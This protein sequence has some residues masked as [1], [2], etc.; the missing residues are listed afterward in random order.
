MVLK[1]VLLVA[2]VISGILLLSLDV[3]QSESA[4]FYRIEV[5]TLDGG[6]LSFSSLAGK[7]VLL[8]FFASWCAPCVAE[9]P[10]I[11]SLH[12]DFG[13]EMNF[14]GLAFENA[15]SARS[16]VA[17]TGVT[18]RTGLDEGGVLL[19][20]FDGIAMPT[21]VFIDGAGNIVETRIGELSDAA[22]RKKLSDLFDIAS[23]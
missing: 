5:T 1:G 7:P 16:I 13:E 23:K 4:E 21:T 11:E 10:T 12:Q 3:E 20:Q 18:Y 6:S 8:N 9:M 19:A 15:Q 17:E 2:V 14:V 22:F